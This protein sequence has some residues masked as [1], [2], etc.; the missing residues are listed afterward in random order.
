MPG[1]HLGNPRDGAAAASTLGKAWCVGR[2]EKHRGA[3][4]TSLGQ[5]RASGLQTELDS[6]M[7]VTGVNDI[8]H[9][10]VL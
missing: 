4:L 10:D 8:D 3:L 5:R 7:E 2:Q 1:S 9:E 6:P